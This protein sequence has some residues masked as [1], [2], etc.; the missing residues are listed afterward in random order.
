MAIAELLAMLTARG[1]DL[2]GSH[3]GIPTNTAMDVAALLAGCSDFQVQL[4]RAKY[5][6]ESRHM[7]WAMWFG[8]LMKK[9]RPAENG[10]PVGRVETLSRITLD[11]FVLPNVCPWCKGV[12]QVEVD[13]KMIV[14]D[15]CGGTGI[16]YVS[17]RSV[18]R[19]LDLTKTN[20]KL[21]S[22]WS[23]R[24]NECRAMLQKEEGAAIERAKTNASG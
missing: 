20:S 21:P 16:A 23:D 12:G 13:Q 22:V 10:W 15:G 5:C 11:E 7:L 24:L 2:K 19:R 14:C 17:D 4:M 6:G 1:C 18:A 8:R 9:Y 3:G